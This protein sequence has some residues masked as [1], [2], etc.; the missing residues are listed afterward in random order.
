MEQ[1]TRGVGAGRIIALVC[2]LALIVLAIYVFFNRQFIF[3]QITLFSYQPSQEIRVLAS[4]TGMTPEAERYFFAS[5]PTIDER[6][7]FNASCK[8]GDEQT[9]V[10]GCYAARKIHVFNIT[11]PRLKGIKEVTSAH[12]MLHAA[13]DR[14]SDADRN[15]LHTLIDREMKGLN[16]ERIKKLVDTYN[17]TEPGQLYNE[18]HSILATE[19]RSLQPQLEQYYRRYFADRSK[20]VAYSEGYESVFSKLRARQQ[21][22]VTQV[23]TLA[24]EINQRTASLNAKV[25]T[26][27][28]DVAAFNAKARSGGFKTQSEF[29]RERNALIARQATLQTEHVAVQALIDKYNNLKTELET[30]NLEAQSLNSSIDSSLSPVPSVQ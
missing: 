26:L 23:G 30:T 28:T 22:L 13:Y 1:E 10:L 5:R 20:I 16:D 3:D 15:E 9:I 14:L 19:V 11:D 12:E 7:E 6:T 21:E 17:R 2:N 29:D 18:M 25:E 27:N 24:A 4:D 8:N